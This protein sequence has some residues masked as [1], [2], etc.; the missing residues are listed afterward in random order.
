LESKGIT[1]NFSAPYTPQQNGVV[2]RTNRS[3]CEAAR[4]ILNFAKLPL[5]FVAD[6]IFCACFTQNMSY[7]NKRFNKTPYETLNAREPNVKF[8]YIFGSRCFNLNSKDHLGKFQITADMG[9]FLGYS[10]KGVSYRVLNKRTKRIEKTFNVTFDDHYLKDDIDSFEV[11]QIF[12]VNNEISEPIITFDCDCDRLFGPDE[13]G[14]NSDQNAT[15]KSI[16][17]VDKL[18]ESL[19]SEVH[20]ESST[21]KSSETSEFWNGTVPHTISFEP[22]EVRNQKVTHANISDNSGV[23]NSSERSDFRNATVLPEDSNVQISQAHSEGESQR[24]I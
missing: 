3:L 5:Y 20:T 15:D 1:H 4:T 14:E 17:E 10:T 13:S 11:G 19:P 8:F 18:S 9:I 6:A 2:E 23:P 24:D 12:P 7:M 21:L 22:S 16:H